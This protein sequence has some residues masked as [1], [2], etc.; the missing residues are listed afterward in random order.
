L[1]KYGNPMTNTKFLLTTNCPVK[2][3]DKV[4]FSYR[5]QQNISM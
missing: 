4:F 3:V 1:D 2:P 5:R